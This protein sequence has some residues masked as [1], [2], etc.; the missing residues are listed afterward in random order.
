MILTQRQAFCCLFLRDSVMRWVS[1]LGPKWIRLT[2]NG[3]NRGLFQ[4]RFQYI[5]ASWQFHWFSPFCANLNYVRPKSDVPLLDRL[6][7]THTW[8]DVIW[9]LTQLLSDDV[10]PVSE[11]WSG[12]NPT[13]LGGGLVGEGVGLNNIAI[14]HSMNKAWSTIDGKGICNTV[15]IKHF[16]P[17]V[18]FR[19]EIRSDFYFRCLRHFTWLFVCLFYLRREGMSDK[20]EHKQQNYI[21]LPVRVQVGVGSGSG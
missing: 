9:F 10:T 8:L 14:L 20:F 18:L 21:Q 1:D 12:N 7:P 17:A 6:S 13:V 4:I 5:L 3:T 11:W 2:P 16:D 19:V 15:F